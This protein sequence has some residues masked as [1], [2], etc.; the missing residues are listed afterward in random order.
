MGPRNAPSPILVLRSQSSSLAWGP[1]GSEETLKAFLGA[2]LTV[3]VCMWQEEEGGSK[4]K[5]PVLSLQMK[6]QKI[7]SSKK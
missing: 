5:R 6:H 2:R 1:A 4:G 7:S 3:H